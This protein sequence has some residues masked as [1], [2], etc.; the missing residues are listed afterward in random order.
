M[1]SRNAQ[2]L[3]WMSRYLERGGHLCRLLAGQFGVIHDRSVDDIDRSWQR[4]YAAL[5]REPL[6]GG[7]QPSDGL[8][9]IMLADAYTL[10]DDLTFERQNPDSVLSCF[11]LARE[12]ARQ[13]RN[14][15]SHEMWTCL[16]AAYLEMNEKR[17]LDI[18]ESRAREF[19]LSAS[20]AARAF[21]GWAANNMYRDH[22]WQFLLLGQYIERAL[23][24][25]ALVKAQI[26]IYP[27]SDPN[28]TPDWESL[29]G[30][31]EACASYRRLHSIEYAPAD[32]VHFLV[33]DA[34]L[35]N[36]VRHALQRASDTLAD[37]NA[38]GRSAKTGDIDCPLIQANSLLDVD[39]L[40]RDHDDDDAACEILDGVRA[41]CR[42]LHDRVQEAYF[43]YA[44][45]DALDP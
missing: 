30:M 17:L 43:H 3:Y 44:I 45:E 10:T 40:R 15:I 25:T 36:S 41:A 26:R 8:E 11:A 1:L 19:F 12:N 33:A 37:I 2:G 27:T 42:T 20:S 29:L 35:S 39:W 5:E 38:E 7:L 34:R 28:R 21:S 6:G 9:P 32:V 16:N 23:L 18:W 24:I 22:G 14:H 31:C 4:I 13:N